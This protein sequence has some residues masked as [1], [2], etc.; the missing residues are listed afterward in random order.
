MNK[1]KQLKK[2]RKW[3]KRQLV[4]N[5]KTAVQLADILGISPQN[6]NNR[7]LGKVGEFEATKREIKEALKE[8]MKS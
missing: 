6:L 8:L 4:M 5:D 1:E 2:F 7:F 3:V